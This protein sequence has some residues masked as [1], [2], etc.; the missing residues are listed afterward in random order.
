[1]GSPRH[2]EKLLAL[3]FLL[4]PTQPW[5]PLPRTDSLGICWHCPEHP[6]GL[7][8]TMEWLGAWNL[9]GCTSNVLS[10]P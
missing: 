5:S 4:T 1:M 10:T 3:R 7:G 2:L 9:I 6:A 8:V